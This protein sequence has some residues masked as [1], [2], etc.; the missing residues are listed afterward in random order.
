M[1]F[2]ITVVTPLYGYTEYCKTFSESMQALKLLL[3]IKDKAKGKFDISINSTNNIEIE[4]VNS[5]SL[6]KVI[7]A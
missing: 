3:I 2:I 7:A 5:I 6:H 4:K 1:K